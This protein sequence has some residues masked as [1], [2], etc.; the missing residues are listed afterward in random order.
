[1]KSTNL[2]KKIV[3]IIE[4]ETDKKIDINKNFIEN[5]MDS[6]DMIS[7]VM[8]IEKKFKLKIPDKKLKSLKNI[9]DLKKLIEEK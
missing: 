9:N 2:T 3:T 4:K 5:S 1:M 7:I 6:L 8:G